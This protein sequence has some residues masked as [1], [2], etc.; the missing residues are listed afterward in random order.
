[1]FR[2]AR[3]RNVVASLLVLT[4]GLASV[5]AADAQPRPF[6]IVGAG[7]GP[8]G[9]PLPGEPAR[10][11]WVIGTATR[12]GRH[13]G[14]GSV[15]TFSAAPSAPTTISGEFGSGDPFVFV[16]A[17]GDRLV[18]YYG[19]TDKGAATPGT[20]DLDIVGTADYGLGLE[21]EAAWIAEFVVQPELCTGRFAGCTGSWIMYAYSAP[22]VLGSTDPVYYAW[23]GEGELTYS[24]GR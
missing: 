5:S 22:F 19:R 23:E 9:L 17:N 2:S 3:L 13:I 12:L 7:V 6:K 15:Q 18:C 21:V 1:M 11:H 8:D 24:R 10:E 14:Y 16:A 20:F 4:A